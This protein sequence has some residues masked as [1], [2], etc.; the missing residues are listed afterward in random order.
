MARQL[1]FKEAFIDVTE[2]D[3]D[4]NKECCIALLVNWM[5]REGQ[6]GATR[7]RLATALANIGLQNLADR[8]IGM[9]LRLLAL[10]IEY[11]VL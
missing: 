2:S 3:K 1:G 11:S 6:Q 4:C 9:S 10:K 8:L 7:E 5:E